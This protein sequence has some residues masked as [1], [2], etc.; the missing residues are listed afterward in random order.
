TNYSEQVRLLL[1][2]VR[3]NNEDAGTGEAAWSISKLSLP[4]H[5]NFL[6]FDFVAMGNNNPGQYIY[7]YKMEGVDDEWVLN[8]DAQTVRYNLQPGEYTFKMYAGRYFDKD[9]LPMKQLFISI[10][11]PF[12]RTWWFVAAMLVLIVGLLAFFINQFNKARY[13]RK[14][15]GLNAAHRLQVERERISRDLHDSIGAYANAVLYS[16]QLLEEEK[17][18]QSRLNLM[19]ELKFASK[20]IITSLRETIWALKKDSYTTQDCILRIRNFVQPLSRHYPHIQFSIEGEGSSN[21]QLHYGTALH[22]VRIIQEAV[23]N[24]IKHSKTTAI[25]ITSSEEGKRW[26]LQV[27]DNGIGFT[28]TDMQDSGNQYGLGNMKERAAEAGF[29]LEISS[30][31]GR[32]SSFVITV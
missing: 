7:Q 24:A 21:H 22:V 6:A 20:D 4:H 8:E 25:T 3:V 13:R 23:T 26:R 29:A 18:E 19:M 9:A 16:T 5:K 27:S 12:Y 28:E 2:R 1:T 14:V 15:E 10:H 31:P 17:E 11:P 32:G 30:A